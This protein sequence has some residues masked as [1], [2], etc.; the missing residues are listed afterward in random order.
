MTHRP[1]V[2]ICS[3]VAPRRYS[4]KSVLK[5][6]APLPG[7]EP[8]WRL[9]RVLLAVLM[10]LA[11]LALTPTVASAESSPLTWSAP[12]MTPLGQYPT[13]D[14][15][16]DI[17]CPTTTF[18]MGVGFDGDAISWNGSTWSAVTVIDT[19]SLNIIT[20]VSCPT[21]TF[22][23]AV[24]DSGNAMTWN[25]TTWSSPLTIDDGELDSVSCT[26]ASFCMAIGDG[27]FDWDGDSWSQLPPMAPYVNVY[28]VSCT[29]PS[30]CMATGVGSWAVW[31]GSSWSYPDSEQNIGSDYSF[32]T[33]S[34]FCMSVTGLTYQI[35]DGNSW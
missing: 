18:C 17:S 34:T 33:S 11:G 22:C 3:A 7:I 35:W 8:R 12:V 30:F 25:G 5:R 21:R 10:A 16:E 9:A 29:G 6:R 4:S 28:S 31:D 2:R 24:D 13:W 23:A 15:F 1:L 32:C 20:S 26:S 27:T 19:S 14:W